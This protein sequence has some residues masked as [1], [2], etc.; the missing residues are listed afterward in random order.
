M[1]KE[2]VNTNDNEKWQEYKSR[3]KITAAVGKA[4]AC[5]FRTK[6]NDVKIS[7][8]YWR[9]VKDATNLSE[10]L[11]PIGPLKID[12]GSL[13][14]CDVE[15]AN[16]MDAYFSLIGTKLAAQLP[17]YQSALQNETGIPEDSTDIP[18]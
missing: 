7:S 14:V 9:L 12:D 8:A 10:C 18:T 6:V 4:K 1:F 5:F 13:V 15:K 16:I 2:A 11:Q 17:A 3:N